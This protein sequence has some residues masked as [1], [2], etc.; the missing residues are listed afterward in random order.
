L[1]RFASD[2]EPRG[3]NARQSNTTC[4]TELSATR[5]AIASAK[6]DLRFA[7]LWMSN[8]EGIH[9]NRA[10]LHGAKLSHA[11]LQGADLRCANL[12][13]ATIID[14]EI[15]NQISFEFTNLAGATFISTPGGYHVNDFYKL[16]A[17]NLPDKDW[18]EWRKTNFEP[19]F[20]NEKLGKDHPYVHP[21]YIRRMCEK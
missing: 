1:L 10:D 16:G 21:D 6:Y 20:L 3:I 18:I 4:S 11:S 19:D 13:G 2:K 5:E 9:L 7:N 14:G 12:S 8:L 15:D 17:I